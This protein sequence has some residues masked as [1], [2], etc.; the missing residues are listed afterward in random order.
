MNINWSLYPNFS[1]AEFRCR[2]TGKIDMD[3]LF[4]AAL[5]SI[6]T[7]FGRPMRVTS[8]YRHPSHPVEARKGH[9]NG[10]HTRGT[11]C[12]IACTSGADRFI[13]VSLALRHGIT[14][15]GIAPTFLHLGIGAPGLPQNVIWEYA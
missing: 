7:D 5:Q 8:G 11:C 9:S 15:I 4:L 1:E 13:L 12:D 3:P 10:E 14:R 2:H 6:R